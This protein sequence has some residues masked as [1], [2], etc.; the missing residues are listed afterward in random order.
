[1]AQ[2]FNRM[3]FLEALFDG[4]YRKSGK[5]IIVKTAT[6]PAKAGE[7]RYFPGYEK[8][9]NAKFADNTHVF[10]GV[11]PRE[12][13]KP[14]KEHIRY[15]TALWAGLDIGANGFSG[16]QN[17]FSSA[18]E[19]TEAILE[20]PLRPSI[21]VRSGQGAHLYWLLHD[22]MELARPEALEGLLNLMNR[23]LRC[24][25][26]VGADSFMRLPGTANPRY[27]KPHNECYVEFLDPDLRYGANDFK[28]LEGK[29]P[30]PGP[31]R[32]AAP[33]QEASAGNGSAD[34]ADE[35]EYAEI[36]EELDDS[37]AG[38][39]EEQLDNLAGK[40]V[41]KMSGQLI[42]LLADRIAAKVVNQTVD[43]IVEKI[44]TSIPKR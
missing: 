15:V 8:L 16:S 22:V 44:S 31:P 24:E 1:M 13:M 18:V 2:K 40:I 19:L 28:N 42:D 41:E 4:Y 5:F 14:E 38:L 7:V 29:L 23:S 34:S 6:D 25:T 43:R 20:F 36:V 26:R 9:A 17:Y 21:L 32:V 37:L 39:T 33:A 30:K 11:C 35:V 3:D 12:K 10:F 27:E